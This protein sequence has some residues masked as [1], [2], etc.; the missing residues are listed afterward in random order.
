MR[1]KVTADATGFGLQGETI[2]SYLF[3][4]GDGTVLES[5]AVPIAHHTYSKIGGFTVN[6]RLFAT[7][8]STISISKFVQTT[9]DTGN[10][11]GN[12]SFESNSAG[13][14]TYGKSLIRRVSGAIDGAFAL[15]VEASDTSLNKFGINDVPNWVSS[16]LAA[17]IGYRFSAFVR[18]DTD[19]GAVHLRIREYI[20]GVKIGP[21]VVSEPISLSPSWQLVT[22]D[23]I[24]HAAGSSL[25]LQIQNEPINT[26]E[27]FEVDDISIEV[28]P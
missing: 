14:S 8:G 24:S 20:N 2:D 19:S 5:Q 6:L 23:H 13:W 11:V 17:G 25:D 26:G 28:I 22:V 16:S 27:I 7:D 21:T 9:D 10:V 4:F 15:E 3:D 18:S 1:L 12:P